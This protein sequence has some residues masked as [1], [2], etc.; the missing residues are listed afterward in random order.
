[1]ATQTKVVVMLMKVPM[2]GCFSKAASLA[3]GL[4]QLRYSASFLAQFHHQ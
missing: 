3:A 1:M 2:T 4:L